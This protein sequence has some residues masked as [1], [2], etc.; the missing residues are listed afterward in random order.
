M[1]LLI[2]FILFNKQCMNIFKI[3][4]SGD[5]RLHE[6]NI[7]AFLGY[8]LNPNED[9]GLGSIFLKQILNQH[10]NQNIDNP[11][12]KELTNE[13]GIKDL[14]IGSE[15]TIDVFLEQGFKDIKN[16]IQAK[17]IATNN[18]EENTEGEDNSAAGKKE[19]VDIMIFIYHLKMGKEDAAIN[20]I[21]KRKVLKHIILLEVKIQDKSA[22]SNQLL[23][24]MINSQTLFK[25]LK[26]QEKDNLI[27]DIDDNVI[28]N[29]SM[30]YITPKGPNTDKSFTELKVSEFK[31]HPISHIFWSKAH[32]IEDLE[33]NN[34][35]SESGLEESNS[36]EE[37]NTFS[38]ETILDKIIN[39]DFD[40]KSEIIPEYTKQTLQ[41]FSNFIYT[42]FKPIV[43]QKTGGDM[44]KMIFSKEEIF[45]RIK[46][47]TTS[48]NYNLAIEI[49]DLFDR[50][51]NGRLFPRMP[52]DGVLRLAYAFRS[53]Q[54]GG[55]VAIQI[56]FNKDKGLEIALPKA[57]LENF[58]H[59]GWKNYG[60]NNDN[61][62]FRY[63]SKYIKSGGELKQLAKLIDETMENAIKKQ[64][65]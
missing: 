41:S 28:Q 21:T 62:I 16:V 20:V 50:T 47:E 11:Y 57:Y 17:L 51:Y 36:E 35:L 53:N 45:E 26:E 40:R 39:N 48:S 60:S 9:H 12:L 3:L 34:T 24:Q 5:G 43:K 37:D 42:D 38:I 46:S 4:A 32:Q 33:T 64:N 29:M 58:N 8:L 59:E 49:F 65:T 23:N 31:S 19:I 44:K 56:N 10:Y 52:K 54:V 27:I 30:I 14:S 61:T 15:Y 22:I 18:Q 2:I 13:N 25:L 63:W 1:Q 6:P 55:A 7:S